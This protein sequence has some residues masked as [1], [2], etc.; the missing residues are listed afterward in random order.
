MNNRVLIRG[1]NM[2]KLIVLAFAT[3]FLSSC[4]TVTSQYNPDHQ[5][6]VS[7]VNE[8][9]VERRHVEDKKNWDRPD[10]PDNGVIDGPRP[11]DK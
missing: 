6:K 10:H 5:D 9:Q 4:G 11:R 8:R 3:V 7:H 2:R 1:L